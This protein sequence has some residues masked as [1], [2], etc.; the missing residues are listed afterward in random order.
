MPMA[1]VLYQELLQDLSEYLSLHQMDQF[2]AGSCD[3]P[4]YPDSTPLQAAA[5]QL[6]NSFLKKYQDD[7]SAEAD[8]RCLD[9]FLQCNAQ[10][11]DWV[12]DVDGSWEEEVFGEFK[13]LIYDFFYPAG[14]PLISSFPQILDR[15]R[16]GPGASLLAEGN[17]FYT[18]LFSSP[19]SVTSEVL[20]DTYVT[21]FSHDHLWGPAEMQRAS[22]YGDFE[23]VAGNRLS[24]VPK[25]SSISRSICTEPV[26]NMFFQLGLGAILEARL[27][28][29]FGIDLSMQPDI[30]REL[31]RI[32][33]LDFK[34]NRLSTI[35]L[36]C[37]SDSISLAM[38][39]N[40]L[41]RQVLSWF[42]LTRS[43]ACVL[44]NG[45]ELQLNMVSTMGNGFTFPLQTVLFACAVVAVY[46]CSGIRVIKPGFDRTGNFG[47]FGDDII[48][49]TKVSGRVIRLLNILGFSV[50]SD[51]SFFEGPFRESCGEDYFRGLNVRG[52]YVKTLRTVT[53]R[54]SVINQLN[55]WSSRL[56][57]YLPRTVRRLHRSVPKYYVPVWE[58]EDAGIRVPLRFLAKVR[59]SDNNSF[60]YRKWVTRPKRIKLSDGKVSVP[61]GSKKRVYNPKGLLLAFLRGDI[62]QG[63]ISVRQSTPLYSKRTGV[64][65]SWDT[66]PAFDAR[67][68]IGS[69][70][71]F[72]KSTMANM[73]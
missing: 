61:K 26:L 32:G 43:K 48:C 8:K 28:Q 44:P 39:R 40:V 56:G 4:W 15:G 37:A 71:D 1:N 22:K 10:C 63:Y 62:E 51:K 50:N 36:S 18:K 35:D 38:L 7:I 57:I 11:K 52:V 47:V 14:M 30:N 65:P 41:P 54:F 9:L 16:V 60:L 17:D 5:V 24:F 42:E 31:A 58:N 12:Y 68:S 23:K 67:K 55:V 59:Y 66:A 69:L 73:S 53:S 25:K 45:D 34:E 19:L 13:R 29:F 6:G 2:L 3:V 72:Y 64:A 49:H 46:R 33:S 27:R 21:H 20:Y 70:A